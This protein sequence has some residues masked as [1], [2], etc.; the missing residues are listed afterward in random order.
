VISKVIAQGGLAQDME[1]VESPQII[2]VENAA[3]FEERQAQV[4]LSVNFYFLEYR[5]V[6][7]SRGMQH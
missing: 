7:L 5:H 2:K 4:K 1:G 6:I 3:L